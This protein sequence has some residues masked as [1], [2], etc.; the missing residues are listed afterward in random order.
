MK[1][2]A[3]YFLN[4]IGSQDINVNN[5]ARKL[6]G[7]QK[8]AVSLARLMVRNSLLL[9]LDEP[10]ASLG[11]EQKDA[12]LKFVRDQRKQKKSIV[13]ISHDVDEIISTCDRIAVM[14]RGRLVADLPRHKADAEIVRSYLGKKHENS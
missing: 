13:F 9:V 6:S 5:S 10:I 14:D 1:N 4:V 2:K 8:K 11:I 12:V 3:K 7:G